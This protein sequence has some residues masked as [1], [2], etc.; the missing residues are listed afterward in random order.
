MAL[1]HELWAHSPRPGAHSPQPMAILGPEFPCA[2]PSQT[3]YGPQRDER[4]PS[5]TSTVMPKSGFRSPNPPI[6][7]SSRSRKPCPHEEVRQ[8]GSARRSSTNT[9]S[10][11]PL[12][13]HQILVPRRP[14]FFK[15]VPLASTGSKTASYRYAKRP[16]DMAFG[17]RHPPSSSTNRHAGVEACIRARL[18]TPA[19]H[20]SVPV[21]ERLSPWISS[22]LYGPRSGTPRGGS[23]WRS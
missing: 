16:L 3:T 13:R 22:R 17:A 20:K 10:S 5:S 18:L 14:E 6:S 2:L 19:T 8:G 23:N 9:S 21:R 1:G 12:S 4:A 11:R 15:P 7:T